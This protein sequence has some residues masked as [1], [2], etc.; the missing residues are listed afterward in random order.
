VN[1]TGRAFLQHEIRSYIENEFRFRDE[2]LS[3]DDELVLGPSAILDQ[4]KL[5]KDNLINR[6]ASALS[7]AI[8]NQMT[9]RSRHSALRWRTLLVTAIRWRIK[10]ALGPMMLLWN[11]RIRFLW[12]RLRYAVIQYSEAKGNFAFEDLWNAMADLER[13]RY[14]VAH[15]DPPGEPERSLFGEGILNQ[16]GFHGL[17]EWRGSRFRWTE[18]VA[19]L[20]LELEVD[21]YEIGIDTGGIRGGAECD[22]RFDLVFNGRQIE[23]DEIEIEQGCIRFCV[24]SGSM[25]ENSAQELLILTQC[26]KFPKG[27]STETRQL[28]MPVRSVSCRC[29]SNTIPLEVHRAEDR[30]ASKRKGLQRIG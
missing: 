15:P 30:H 7:S 8:W 28:G 26:V 25:R 5:W 29:L 9:R 19:L 24:R 20:S 16:I 1:L 22:F 13:A 2:R 6:T 27:R 12:K 11:A 14:C 17:E 3:E 21:D 4:R 23:R 10:A 18:P